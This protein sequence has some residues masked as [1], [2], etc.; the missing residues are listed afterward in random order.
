MKKVME[1]TFEKG[2]GLK[3]PVYRIFY[4]KSFCVRPQETKVFPPPVQVPSKKKRTKLFIIKRDTYLHRK[5]RLLPGKLA[6]LTKRGGK[7]DFWASHGKLAKKKNGA[8]KTDDEN[9]N[10]LLRILLII[11][12]I[13]ITTLLYIIMNNN[14]LVFLSNFWWVGRSYP[15][16]CCSLTFLIVSF[17][18]C[19]AL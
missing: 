8:G 15:E 3:K 12:T 7:S 19:R 1:K 14:V 11:I 16:E 4:S 5:N 17:S 13:I 9:N 10:F 6:R 18:V 2:K